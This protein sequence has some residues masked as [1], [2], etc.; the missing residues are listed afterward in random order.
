MFAFAFHKET[1]IPLLAILSFDLDNIGH[2][3]EIGMFLGG[4]INP[5]LRIFVKALAQSGS[6]IP[7]L[8]Y[9]HGYGKTIDY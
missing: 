1:I 2:T 6:N 8:S 9:L 4:T 3:N 7:H 5:A